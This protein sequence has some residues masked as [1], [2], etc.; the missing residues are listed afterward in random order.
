MT[1]IIL[2][3]FIFVF[4]VVAV[5]VAAVVIVIAVFVSVVVVIVVAVL[6]STM[7]KNAQ[8]L[9][10]FFIFAEPQ[11]K[12]NFDGCATKTIDCDK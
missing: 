3:R 10:P 7:T 12:T 2:K 5:V 4:V 8:N 11:I 6:V 1:L 9:L